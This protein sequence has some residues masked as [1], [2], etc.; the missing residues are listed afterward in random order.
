[1]RVCGTLYL[2]PIDATLP[3]DDVFKRLF[4]ILKR[5][6]DEKTRLLASTRVHLVSQHMSIGGSK[7]FRHSNDYV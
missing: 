7:R 6:V 5:N 3:K 4:R 1:M 2:I